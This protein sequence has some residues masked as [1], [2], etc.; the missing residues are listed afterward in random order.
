MPCLSIQTLRVYG[1][2]ANAHVFAKMLVHV[3]VVCL[4]P[5]NAEC[6][7]HVLEQV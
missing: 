7:S 3:F 4:L 6:G 2:I 5:P 1:S